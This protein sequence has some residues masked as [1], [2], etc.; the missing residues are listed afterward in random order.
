MLACQWDWEGG[1]CNFICICI[2]FCVNICIYRGREVQ[3]LMR[4]SEKLENAK[5]YFTKVGSR[6]YLSNMSTE[7]C[8][9]VGE[10]AKTVVKKERGVPYSNNTL[11][12]FV[13]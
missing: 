13:T 1:I 6:C 8:F 4:P 7:S 11:L 9:L 10:I 5:T 3:I 12:H 2:G